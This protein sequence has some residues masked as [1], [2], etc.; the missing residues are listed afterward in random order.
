MAVIDAHIHLFTEDMARDPIG[1]A[2]RQGESVW[3]DCVAP[4]DRPSLQGWPTV[5]Q[6]L[7]HMDAAQVERVV[8][9]GWYWQ[10]P[11]SCRIQNQFYA[12]LIQRYPDRFSAFVSLH[13]PSVSSTLETIDW[14]QD[15]GF[16]GVGEIHPQAQ[17]FSL[18]DPCWQSVMEKI[19]PWKA[20]VTL[21]VTDP[22]SA[23]HPGKIETP[24]E[25]YLWLAQTWPDQVIILAHLGGRLPLLYPGSFQKGEYPNIFFDCAAIPLLYQEDFLWYVSLVVDPEKILFG[26]DYP[27]RTFPRQQREPGFDLA[28]EHLN[29]SDLSQEALSLILYRNIQRLLPL[30]QS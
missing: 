19:A 6:T 15:Q 13:P 10:N 9:Q 17:N 21:H 26:T 8:L 11:D 7:R 30:S 23:P 5:K 4:P 3:R 25:D 12:E 18:G 24:L 27:L 16:C 2:N 14:A 22:L 20:P 1:W 28:I 29:K